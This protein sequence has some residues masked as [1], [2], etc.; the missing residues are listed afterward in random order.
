VAAKSGLY[1]FPC[2]A[3][4]VSLVLVI[5]DAPLALGQNKQLHQRKIFSSDDSSFAFDIASSNAARGV[6]GGA[7]VRRAR[8]GHLF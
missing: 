7:L 4:A 2:S 6:R 3:N 8:T 5:S 1:I